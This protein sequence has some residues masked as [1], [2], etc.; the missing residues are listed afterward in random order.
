MNQNAN[1]GLIPFKMNSQQE[2]IAKKEKEMLII[3]QNKIKVKYRE[4]QKRIPKPN[5][6][7]NYCAIFGTVPNSVVDGNSTLAVEL[8][9]LFILSMINIRQEVTIPDCFINFRGKK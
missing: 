7:Q 5:L 4:I 8:I 2:R 1:V 9:Q 6:S 3:H